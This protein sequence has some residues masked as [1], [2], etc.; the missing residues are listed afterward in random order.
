MPEIDPDATIKVR[1]PLGAE[2]V[3]VEPR[4]TKANPFNPILLASGVAGLALLGGAI[5][6]LFGPA[7]V[8]PGKDT[9]P[10]LAPALVQPAVVVPALAPPAIAPPVVVHDVLPR[11]D[12]AEILAQRVAAPVPMWFGPNPR[13]LVVD[14]PD[15]H[16]QGM[17]FNRVAAFIEKAGLPRDRVLSDSELAAA[18]KAENAT[19]DTYYYGHDYRIADVARFYA[20][21]DRQKIA[22]AE[23]EERL[24]RII[25][26]VGMMHE[27]A[28]AGV[29]SIPREGSDTFVDPSGRQSLLR[30][31]L[32]HGEFFTVPA[33]AA[34]VRRF[35]RENLTEPERAA[36]RGF[37]TRQGYDPKDE[38]LL[39][40]EMQA[41]LIHTTDKR[42]FSP[43]YV[44]LSRTRAES[45]RTQFVT[46][47]PPGWLQDAAR[48]SL[49]SLP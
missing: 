47:M 46:L 37:L 21:A 20:T 7:S 45:L 15:L 32:S 2:P 6:M 35:W 18:I 9:A 19:A 40:N 17:A 43:N 31:E 27:A 4:A 12:E 25:T 49:P 42:Y 16:S 1:R 36:F 39:I 10:P 23:E 33:Y 28:E 11:R 29:I 41:H 3:R 13:V 48:K 34:F 26:G 14:Y 24:R 44:G 8:V 22:L 5:Y 38:D 30:H